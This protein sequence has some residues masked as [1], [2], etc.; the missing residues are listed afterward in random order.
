LRGDEVVIEGV[1]PFKGWLT[2]IK[3]ER[4]I[5][6]EPKMVLW[7]EEA[8]TPDHWWVFR[9]R[10]IDKDH[11][12]LDFINSGLDDFDEV[13]TRE[14]AEKIIRRNIDNAELYVEGLSIHYLRVAEEDYELLHEMLEDKGIS[15]DF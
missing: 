9:L 14:E 3:G 1:M 8:M 7:S 10:V 2:K 11:I 13:Q 4:F 12:I 15:S 6:W 5:T